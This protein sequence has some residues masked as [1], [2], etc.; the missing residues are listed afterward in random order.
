M[1]LWGFPAGEVARSRRSNL[2][3]F[4]RSKKAV[5]QIEMGSG[6]SRPLF[7]CCNVPPRSFLFF[8]RNYLQGILVSFSYRSHTA[9][10]PFVQILGHAAPLQTRGLWASRSAGS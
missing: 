9:L 6:A 2:A 8:P 10:Q 1:A 3:A 4:G 5:C 7:M